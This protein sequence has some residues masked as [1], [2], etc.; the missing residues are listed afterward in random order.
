M[1]KMKSL[2]VQWLV[3]AFDYLQE[4]EQFVVNGFKETVEYL[5]LS[6]NEYALL[7]LLVIVD[8]YCHLHVHYVKLHKI[9]AT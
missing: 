4:N 2:A 6:P 5:M 7:V 8:L 9:I 3:G 1:S